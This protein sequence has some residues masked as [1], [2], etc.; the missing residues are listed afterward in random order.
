[1]K[2]SR[3]RR[4][5]REARLLDVFAWA[6]IERATMEEDPCA[7]RKGELACRECDM[8]ELRMQLNE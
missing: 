1:M 8:R 3:K 4:I 6:L 5:V 2:K 7:E